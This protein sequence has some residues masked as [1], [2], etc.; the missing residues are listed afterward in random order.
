M[1]KP[2]SGKY[3]N[4]KLYKTRPN[5]QRFFEL[6]RL[7]IHIIRPK[8]CRNFHHLYCLQQKLLKLLLFNPKKILFLFP[9][10]LVCTNTTILLDL[11][12]TYKIILLLRIF[13]DKVYHHLLSFCNSS[14]VTIKIQLSSN[15][16]PSC[17]LIFAIISW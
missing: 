15:F 13:L 9:C 14:S 2:R 4:K 7:F 11:M 6:Y 5:L 1:N 10:L 3:Q 16:F 12:L 17:T 8:L